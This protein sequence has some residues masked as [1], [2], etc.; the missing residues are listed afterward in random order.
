MA[1]CFSQPYAYIIPYFSRFVK[2]FRDKILHKLNVIFAPKIVQVAQ[3]IKNRPGGVRHRDGKRKRGQKPSLFRLD[4][5]LFDLTFLI[6]LFLFQFA[7]QD[8]LP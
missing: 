5:L 6:F 2:G 7:F 3:E 4:Y 8:D 1:V